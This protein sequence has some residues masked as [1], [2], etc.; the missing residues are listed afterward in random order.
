MA[1]TNRT[2]SACCSWW[3]TAEARKSFGRG[4]ENRHVLDCGVPTTLNQSSLSSRFSPS[5]FQIP[6]NPSSLSR[7]FFSVVEEKNFRRVQ[8]KVVFSERSC[9]AVPK[10]SDA[11]EIVHEVM[12]AEYEGAECN[13]GIGERDET[14]CDRHDEL[15]I[16]D[17][18]LRSSRVWCESR[19]RVKYVG[20][21]LRIRIY[22]CGATVGDE[23]D[24]GVAMI[25]GENVIV[26]SRLRVGD[27][28]WVRHPL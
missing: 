22:M 3:I 20:V 5:F 2:I 9:V 7:T 25:D 13:V 12:I 19:S 1:E 28:R 18:E 27:R 24:G 8:G 17:F 14:R 6:S 16:R 21:G 10:G 26:G 15:T 4:N 23:G 11:E